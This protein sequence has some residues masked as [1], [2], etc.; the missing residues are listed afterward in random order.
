MEEDE[1]VLNDALN[2]KPETR[3][4]AQ[5]QPEQQI[6]PRP[7]R[8]AYSK[9]FAKDH[10]DIDFENDK[11]GRYGAMLKDRERLHDYEKHGK[12]F[13]DVLNQNRWIGSMIQALSQN[14]DL[15]PV[16]WMADY[17][18]DIAEAL[19]NEEYRKKISEQIAKYQKNQIE[20]E[21]AV[22]EREKNLDTSADNLEQVRTE[23]GLSDEE[24]GSVW[25]SLFVNIVDPAMR[26]EVSP[27]TWKLIINGI[28]HDSDVDK[29]SQKA[30]MTARNEKIQNK[31]KTPQQQEVP[32]TLSQGTEKSATR[33][34]KKNDF[35]EG[36]TE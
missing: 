27:E 25:K 16:S 7:N 35:W 34:A 14:P 19:N 31:L 10:E 4:F 3:E 1:I 21:N 20:G 2:S 24:T 29:S 33:K 12:A 15:D 28:N 9:M 18:I 36:L 13:S 26:G 23:L 32:P 11:E 22:K 5:Q 17:G 6:K 30:A 8:D